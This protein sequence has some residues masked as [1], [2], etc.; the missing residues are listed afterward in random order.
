[1]AAR[2]KAAAAQMRSSDA[3]SWASVTNAVFATVH[4][5]LRH[6]SP[7]RFFGFNLIVIESVVH[8]VLDG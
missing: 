1:M 2:L 8:Q 5:Q 6:Q 4:E 7:V 3:R